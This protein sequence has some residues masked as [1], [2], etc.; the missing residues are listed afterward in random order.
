MADALSPPVMIAFF[1]ASRPDPLYD[2][3]PWSGVGS[4]AFV[5]P[6]MG[7]GCLGNGGFECWVMTTSLTV[8][9]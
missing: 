6:G 8:Y 9:G 7:C 5:D 3:S 2:L 1:P 4:I